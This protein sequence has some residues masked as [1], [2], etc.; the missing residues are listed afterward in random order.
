MH[1]AGFWLRSIATLI[2]VIILDV[3]TILIAWLLFM[4]K[5]SALVFLVFIAET[6]FIV[7]TTGFKG[8]T[9]GKLLLGIK[10]VDLKGKN[11]GVARSTL[12]Y[13]AKLVSY[14]ALLLGI[15]MII[16]DKKKRGWHD[17][18]SGT[19]VVRR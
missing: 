9:P 5:I 18:V 11:I 13:L 17:K 19:L 10:I 3:P 8:G 16:W 2:D 1:Y 14:S 6:V 7:W 15:L 12:R 4:T